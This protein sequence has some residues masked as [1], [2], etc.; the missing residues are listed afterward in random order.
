MMIATGPH[1]DAVTARHTFTGVPA[2]VTKARAWAKDRLTVQGVDVPMDLPL[3]LTELVANAVRHTRS[4]DPG[5]T[6]VV[7]LS[8][9]PDRVRV[10]VRDNGPR[11]HRTP[12]A[13]AWSP[14]AESGRGLAI[15]NAF[16]DSWGP[17]TAACGVFAEVPR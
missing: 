12:T 17:L 7:R 1:T 2:S 11:G 14:T 5:G 3:V 16:A 8:V 15:V 10:E 9:R 4:G 13:L 6:F